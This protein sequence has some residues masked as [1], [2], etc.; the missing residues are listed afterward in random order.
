MK[1][2][3]WERKSRLVL[4]QRV[5][6]NSKEYQDALKVRSEVFI[7]EQSVPP[8]IEVDDLEREAIHF[9]AYNDEGQ[10]VGAGRLR[11][12]DEKGKVERL[13][14]LKNLR[15]QHIGIR[16]MDKIEA[17]AISCRVPKLLLNS[18]EHA[19]PFYE[20]LGFQVTSDTFMDAGIPHKAMEK[21]LGE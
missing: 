1:R 17:L 15:G 14:V 6:Y 5:D 10:P 3:I 7:C 13:C 4:V 9:V 18:Q 8:E 19:I 21:R 20:K 16:L 11:I 12:F 2:S